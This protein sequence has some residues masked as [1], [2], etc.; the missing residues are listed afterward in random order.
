M[1]ELAEFSDLVLEIY[2]TAIDPKRW[3]EVLE[4]ISHYIGARGAFIF[5][6]QGI[7]PEQRIFAPFFSSSYDPVLVTQYLQVHNQQELVDQEIF[8]RLSRRTDHIQLIGDD[9]LADTEEEL[10]A[11]PNVQ[12][13]MRNGLRY[14]AGALLNKDQLNHDRFALQFSKRGGPVSADHAK[15][16]ELLMPHIAK[17]LN[18]SRPTTQLALKF[19]TVVDCLDQLVIGVCILDSNGSIILSNHEF[20]RQMDWHTVFRKD[21]SGKLAMRTDHAQK[22]LAH[23]RHD[24]SNHGRFGARPRKEAI[25]SNVGGEPHTLCVEIVP[26]HA[27]KEM[28]EAR[29]DGHIIYSMDTGNSYKISGDVLAEMFALTQA[30]A[31]VLELMADGLTNA[32]ISERRSKSVETV[33]SQVKSVLV[34]TGTA[35]RTQA[36]RLATNI[37]S[38]FI[39]DAHHPNG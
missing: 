16:A 9:V 19:R 28:G 23:L 5:E 30:E 31:S 4:K 33:N 10:I 15:R 37:S 1:T 17:A 24:V 29:L 34:K 27:S 26:L 32:Q 38:S 35:N 22:T 36:I 3:S 20:Q 39:L 14:R 2:D 18:V 12:E 7:G 6:L 13:M 8:A 25:I 11:R 21:A